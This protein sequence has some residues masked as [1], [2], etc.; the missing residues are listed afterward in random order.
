MW[1]LPIDNPDPWGSAAIYFPLIFPSAV[2]DE[3]TFRS[4][5]FF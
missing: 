3:T 5:I 4:M 2:G 1:G